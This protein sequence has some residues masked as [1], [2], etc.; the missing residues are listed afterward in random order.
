M[1]AGTAL[2]THP[3]GIKGRRRP[4]PIPV[5]ITKGLT[6]S[7]TRATGPQSEPVSLIVTWLPRR[8]K[9]APAC[10]LE[11]PETFSLRFPPT[12]TPSFPAT[13]S[14]RLPPIITLSFVPT[15]SDRLPPIVIP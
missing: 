1:S 6:R 9:A 13:D 11:A 8:F 10:E 12:V 2:H 7:P 14:A 4:L 15:V 5:R 3:G